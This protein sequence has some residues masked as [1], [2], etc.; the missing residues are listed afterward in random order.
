MP[1]LSFVLLLLLCPLVPAPLLFLFSPHPT[2]LHVL[3]R[4]SIP[5]L[6]PSPFLCLYSF[7]FTPFALNKLYSIQY[8]MA[9]PS[10]GR[11]ASAWTRRGTSFPYTLPYLHQSIPSLCIFFI[12]HNN[13]NNSNKS[14]VIPVEQV[15]QWHVYRQYSRI[16]PSIHTNLNTLSF[17]LFT[18]T[19]QL[20]GFAFSVTL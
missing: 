13:S 2:S 18:T 1:L 11:C 4:A 9:G 20:L 17:Q 12:R 16:C 3:T 7:K 5:L 8:C 19:L 15:F 6:S 10:E 14:Q